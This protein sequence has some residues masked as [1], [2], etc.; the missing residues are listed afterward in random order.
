MPNHRNQNDGYH[1]VTKT[2][3][4][5]CKV[6]ENLFDILQQF[7]RSAVWSRGDCF[8]NSNSA[9]CCWKLKFQSKKFSFP[10][11]D[12]TILKLVSETPSH[13]SSCFLILAFL[14]FH[15]EGK[16]LDKQEIKR[17]QR[18]FSVISDV[19]IW[20]CDRSLP[21]H[22]RVWTALILFCWRYKLTKCQ[23]TSPGTTQNG[24]IPE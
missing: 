23:P 22:R 14:T 16:L 6:P 12:V 4:W 9:C 24:S 15:S 7:S 11:T 8:V 1:E 18:T 13:Y 10:L 17:I 20:A 21:M 5:S 3:L 2:T 19:S